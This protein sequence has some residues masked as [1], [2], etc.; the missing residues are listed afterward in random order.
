MV[1]RAA[2]RYLHGRSAFYLALLLAPP[3]LWM[4]TVYLG[5]L[6]ALLAQSFYAIDEFTAR[7][8]PEFTLK[9]YHQLV[10]HP[11]N[12]DIITR[13]LAMAIAVT[14]ASGIIAFPIA[15][16]VARYASPRMRALFYVGIMLPMWTSYLVKVYAWRLILAKEGI[17]SWALTGLGLGGW[18]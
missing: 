13:T 10:S 14:I 5:S 18:L 6:I 1:S 8:V 3:L 17:L 4:G 15:N 2:S 9:T 16:Y 7:V 12:R 11:A